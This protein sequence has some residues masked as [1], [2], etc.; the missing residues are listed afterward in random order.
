MRPMVAAM[1]RGGDAFVQRTVYGSPED[2]IERLQEYV[3]VGLDKFVLWPVAEP[4]AWAG[5]IELIGREVATY[6]ARATRAA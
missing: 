4:A 2:I 5:Q 6:Y 1:G 3:A